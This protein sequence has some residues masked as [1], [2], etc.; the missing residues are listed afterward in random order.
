MGLLL[1]PAGPSLVAW[2]PQ[3]VS[4]MQDKVCG[5]PLPSGSGPCL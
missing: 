4:E 2:Q 1:I 5:C 3:L